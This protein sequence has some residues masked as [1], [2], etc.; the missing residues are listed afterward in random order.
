[1]RAIVVGLIGAALS[2]EASLAKPVLGCPLD[3]LELVEEGSDGFSSRRFR[4]LKV[5]SRFWRLQGPEVNDFK[6][7]GYVKILV[8][9]EGRQ[10]VIEQT[11]SRYG[12]PANSGV[13][14]DATPKLIEGINPKMRSLKGEQARVNG[15]FYVLGGPLGDET[16]LTPVNC[17]QPPA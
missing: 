4:V 1:M 12:L 10:Y 13:S 5:E 6:P 2:V 16:V 15:L 7:D 11:Y 9:S 14:M 17:K 3:G 8:G